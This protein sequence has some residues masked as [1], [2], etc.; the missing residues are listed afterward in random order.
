MDVREPD[1][2]APE[3]TTRAARNDRSPWNWLLVLPLLATLIPPLYNRQDPELFDIPFFYW[4]QLA[5]IGIGVTTTLIV[6]RKT[7]A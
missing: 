7:R 4:Y 6:Y 5:A 2:R 3:S 1:D